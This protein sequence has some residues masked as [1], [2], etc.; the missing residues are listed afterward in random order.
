M[1][2]LI[3]LGLIALPASAA[4]DEV[5]LRGGG[6]ITGEVLERRR[7]A[8][9]V[10]VGPGRV[11]IPASRVE[12]IVAGA[13]PL[14]LYR[15]RVAALSATDVTG[16]LALAEWARQNDLLTQSRAAFEHVLTLQPNHPVAQQ[17]LGRVL[18]HERWVTPEESYRARGYVS[19]E[20]TW[21]RPEEL[22]AILEERT[23]RA[24][25]DRARAEADARLR[26]AE[27]RARVAEAEARRL[28][29]EQ[30]GMADG[31]IPYSWV[32]AGGAF[33]PFGQAAVPT[34]S[35]F[36][37]DSTG[38]VIQAGPNRP[39]LPR[40]PPRPRPQSGSGDPAQG[41]AARLKH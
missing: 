15:A 26:E 37:G 2:R 29:A 41:R 18:L 22:R 16:W 38:V 31:G 30:R 8:V 6:R 10:E 11:T 4:A 21:L 19:F 24:E 7:D 3:A 34:F 40:C 32:I 5:F 33:G 20:G 9:V 12:R 14:A 27:A 28:E 36:P 17:A 23:A 39:A 13:S 25:A 35:P 1:K